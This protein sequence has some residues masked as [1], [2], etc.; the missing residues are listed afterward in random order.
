[1]RRR[2]RSGCGSSPV[3]KIDSV[4]AA[5]PHAGGGRPGGCVG[6]AA[7]GFGRPQAVDIGRLFSI[8]RPPAART[9]TT[10]PTITWIQSAEETAA[11]PSTHGAMTV[12]APM[13]RFAH[14][15]YAWKAMTAPTASS[16]ITAPETQ[17][18]QAAVLSAV[19]ARY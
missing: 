19:K 12:H 14:S 8:H 13:T 10:A 11:K 16:V 4:Q 17:A 18:L 9:A 3:K 2:S 15:S 6:P 7:L 5:R 1:M